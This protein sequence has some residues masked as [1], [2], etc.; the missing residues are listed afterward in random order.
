[1]KFGVGSDPS[2]GADC[3]NGMRFRAQVNGATQ[4]TT[5]EDQSQT[6]EKSFVIPATSSATFKV[7]VNSLGSHGCDHGFMQNPRV[8]CSQA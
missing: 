4:F 1:M 8:I 7:I 5:D 2:H 3:S 6:T